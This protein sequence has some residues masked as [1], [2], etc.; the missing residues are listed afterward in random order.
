MKIFLKN[1][2]N[3]IL[4]NSSGNC[5]FTFSKLPSD[6]Q[7]VE[8]IQSDTGGLAYINTLCPIY[9]GTTWTIEA[10]V[11]MGDT[12]FSGY[13]SIYNST[14][15][16]DTFEGWINN[17]SGKGNLN[18][19]YN[20]TAVRGIVVLEPSEVYCL[21]AHYTG[22][23]LE[24]YVNGVL[25]NTTTIAKTTRDVSSTYVTIGHGGD[26]TTFKFYYFKLYKDSILLR[27]FIPCYRK[28]DNIIGMYDV[29]NDVF[30]TNSGTGTFLK[31]PDVKRLPSNY[32][33]VEYLQNTGTGYINTEISALNKLFK[34]D[35]Q[36]TSNE[37]R[38]LMGISGSSSAYWGNNKGTWEKVGTTGT[39]KTTLDRV[40]ICYDVGNITAEKTNTWIEGATNK[41]AGSDS[42]W[43]TAAA[44]PLRIFNLAGGSYN[45]KMK[46]YEIKV[47]N[48]QGH[49]LN[50]LIPCIAGGGS[51]TRGVYDL[52][53]N[54]FTA[55]TGSLTV[56][57]YV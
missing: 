57:L 34:I 51:D 20:D 14:L 45:C 39:G 55:A 12:W 47:Y 5:L 32:L 52:V 22:T 50:H 26:Q 49:L 43:A 8:Y 29:I 13:E 25:K 3:Q 6:Y 15:N 18:F 19:R 41:Y 35:L 9:N 7:K 28:S 2:S 37:T 16:S 23:A 36:F 42:N 53:L 27:Y 48:N 33:E 10:K 24:S 4:K 44:N 46:L 30:Y 21:K 31:G 38:Q 56:G 17:V 40:V 1:S 54:K 11:M